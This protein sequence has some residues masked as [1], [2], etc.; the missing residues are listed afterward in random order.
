[1]H[2][3]GN[4]KQGEKIAFRMEVKNSE[5]SNQRG[6]NLQNIQTALHSGVLS[7]FSHVQLFVT[8]WI[9]ACQAPLSMGFSSQAYQSG[10]PCPPPGDL[11]DPRIIRMSLT[12]PALAGRFFTTSTTWEEA[13][14]AQFIKEKT[15]KMGRRPKLTFLQRRHTDDQ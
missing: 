12:S 10:L 6:I 5:Q 14:A 4:Y 1:M 15:Q 13:L 9:V 7:H 11:P 8:L 2:N 3:E